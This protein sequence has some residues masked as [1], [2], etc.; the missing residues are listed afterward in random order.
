MRIA[1][2]YADDPETTLTQFHMCFRVL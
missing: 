1:N 2:K